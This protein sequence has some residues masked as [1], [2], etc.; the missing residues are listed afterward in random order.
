M[1]WR[2]NRDSK[3][4]K[5][6]AQLEECGRGRGRREKKRES[7]TRKWEEKRK[8]NLK[9]EGRGTTEMKENKQK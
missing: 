8:N 1:E 7:Q 2:G 4:G 9:R 6:R 5:E 3:V